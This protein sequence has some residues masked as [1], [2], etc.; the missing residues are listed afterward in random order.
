MTALRALATA[1]AWWVTS[2]L[3]TRTIDAVAGVGLAC[4]VAGALGSGVL[5]GALLSLVLVAA[6]AVVGPGSWRGAVSVLHQPD[7]GASRV[8]A[9]LAPFLVPF[10][11]G[12]IAAF[13]AARAS[14]FGGNARRDTGVSSGGAGLWGALT[15][16]R[17]DLVLRGRTLRKD[18][19]GAAQ[20]AE[21]LG[22]PRSAARWWRAAGEPER[23]RHVLS[24]PAGVNLE[25]AER[26][27]RSEPHREASPRL[28][29]ENPRTARFTIDPTDDDA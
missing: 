11:L 17:P 16:K 15:E 3:A 20:L 9:A 12:V 4:V 29:L 23:A 22:M 28:E 21:T 1:V 7:P 10:G 2:N 27:G 6:S 18:W 19:A 25:L 8:V 5:R 13:V 26:P 24:E 14:G